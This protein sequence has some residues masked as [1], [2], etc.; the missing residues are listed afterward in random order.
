MSRHAAVK[1]FPVDKVIAAMRERGVYLK[2]AS[3]RGISEEAPGVYKN[4]DE[5]VEITHRAGIAR[6]V[7]R[8]RPIGVV[9]G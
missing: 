9:K 8:L 2:A 3:K 6:K 4:V 1:Q 5:V 7:A